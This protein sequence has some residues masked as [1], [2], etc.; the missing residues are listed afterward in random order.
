MKVLL[1]APRSGSS[2]YYEHIDRE[3][4]LLPNVYK[5]HDKA[6]FLNPDIKSEWDTATKIAWL[7]SEREQGREYTFKHHI[8]YL[9]TDQFD[10]YNTWFVDF[11]RNDQVL[12]LKR[13]NLW[14]WALSFMWQELVHWRTAGIVDVEYAHDINIDNTV[15]LQASL[16]QFF[17]IKDQLDAVEGTV[18][19]Y[20]DLALPFSRYHQLSTIVD[21]EQQMQ[22]QGINLEQVGEY[23]EFK[24]ASTAHYT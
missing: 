18:V 5:P 3:N 6:E 14:R 12:V 11:Y 13:K 19:Y 20:E 2:Y 15:D 8:N 9:Q 7:N 17:A 22:Q 16:D 24:K 10:Y 23:Y 21:Y 1:S 4:L